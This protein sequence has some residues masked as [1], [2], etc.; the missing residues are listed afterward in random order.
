MKNLKKFTLIELLVVIAIIG[1]LAALLLPALNKA[2]SVAKEVSCKNNLKQIGL[3]MEGYLNDNE[4]Y[5]PAAQDTIHTFW[6]D[7]LGD[8]DGR[9]LTRTEKMNHLL[10][11]TNPSWKGVASIYRC[12]EDTLDRTAV[13][14]TYFART[15]S[16]L[17]SG[18]PP[19]YVTGYSGTSS[20]ITQVGDPSGTISIAPFP[21]TNNR[22]GEGLGAGLQDVTQCTS[23]SE[24]NGLYQGT[25]KLGL[26]SG[27]YR[28]NALFADTHVKLYDMRQTFP[29]MWTIS[30]DD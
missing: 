13:E 22:L 9:R 25:G 29:R 21:L 23:E 26:H 15:Y 12:P 10:V 18:D 20:N 30:K 16:I 8:Y 2:R 14:G 4:G 3:A 24:S 28:F 17:A 6:D 19:I 27:H 7:H 5:Y 11:G 1:I